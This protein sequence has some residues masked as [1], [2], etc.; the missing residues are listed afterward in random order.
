MAGLERR[1]EKMGK[2]F[3][4]IVRSFFMLGLL[5]LAGYNTWTIAQLRSEVEA[6]RLS[7]SK[8]A[9]PVSR[10]VDSGKTVKEKPGDPVS[11]LSAA[12]RHYDAAQAYLARK[13][14]AEASREMVLA[15][16]A[17]KKA[18][19]NAST[20][21]GDKVREF[22]QAVQSLSSRAEELMGQSEG[23]GAKPPSSVPHK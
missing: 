13:E 10:G 15:T 14:Y 22:Q 17:A 18:G 9:L 11:Q 6:L 12:K 16:E 5:C 20:L 2:L 23:S 4:A 7:Q 19:A 1:R 8:T 21:S 3:G